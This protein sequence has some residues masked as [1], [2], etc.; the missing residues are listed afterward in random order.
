MTAPLKRWMLVPGDFHD[1][2]NRRRQQP[3]EERP[4]SLHFS[5]HPPGRY[6]KIW[7]DD[8][9]VR[10]RGP[11]RRHPWQGLSRH[12]ELV[13]TGQLARLWQRRDR[14][15]HVR[16]GQDASLHWIGPQRDGA[17]GQTGDAHRR[18]RAGTALE[19]HVRERRLGSGRNRLQDRQAISSGERQEAE[20][21][22]DHLALERLSRRHDGRFV[23]DRLAS[24]PRDHRSARA[25]L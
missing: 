22:Q 3:D 18:A 25:W 21:L 24:R 7:S 15:R 13:I 6:S 16:A 1:R 17:H 2:E 10:V 23:G 20:R 14:A 11:C 19:S 8:H 4:R 9:V 12:D 5:D